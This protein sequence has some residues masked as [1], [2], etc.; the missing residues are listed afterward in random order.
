[1][2]GQSPCTQ[3]VRSKWRVASAL[4]FK[5]IMQTS[6]RKNLFIL[7]FTLV[8]VTLGFGVVIPII[9]FYME[10]LGAGGTELGLLVASYAVMRLIF[11]PIW[12]SLSD[13]L[14]RKPIMMIGILGYGLT[15]VLFGFATELWMLF[16]AR[17]L[18]GILSSATSP[19]T[20]AYIGD[21]TSEQDRG[22]G[23]GILG[24]AVGLGTI[25]GPALGGL[26][27]SDSLSTPFFIAGG[28]SFLALLLTW[29]WLPESLPKDARQPSTK[30]IP[31]P[32]IRLWWQALSSPIGILLILAFLL[33]CGLMIF[34]GIFG[35]YA[36]DKFGFGPEQVGVIFMVVG[37]VSAITQGGLT[38]LVTRKW[39]ETPIIKIGML[40]SAISLFLV[41]LATNYW[42]LLITIGLF[43]FTTALLTPAISALT[44]KRAETQQG[45]AMGLSNSFMSLGRIAG[46]LLAGFVFDIN[47]VLPFISGA[48][49]MLLGFITSMIW[50]SEAAPGSSIPESSDQIPSR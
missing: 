46:P 38:G 10:S 29:L 15:M 2:Q 3:Q 12:G 47:A 28:M 36:L 45:M 31:L 33:T 22:S 16:A 18:S 39:G 48:V 42:S 24:A 40:G 4:H 5:I 6:N 13:R 9:P 25:F 11:A 50:L 43:V 41:S 35:L 7:S 30:R 32:E 21:S 14:G 26:L 17:I 44:S 49:I 37:L 20:M 34:Y 8:V 23:M 1:M 27:A 19:T